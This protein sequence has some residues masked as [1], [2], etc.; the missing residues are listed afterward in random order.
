MMAQIERSTDGL[1]Q[2]VQSLFVSRELNHEHDGK[3]T[4]QP[5]HGGFPEVALTFIQCACDLGNYAGAILTHQSQH[6]PFFHRG[7]F[8]AVNELEKHDTHLKLCQTMVIAL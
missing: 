5:Y 3:V 7:S 1:D 2:I 6:E 8:Q 4:A